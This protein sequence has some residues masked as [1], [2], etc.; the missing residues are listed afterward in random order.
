YT[1]KGDA[2]RAL[3]AP[4]GGA[5]LPPAGDGAVVIDQASGQFILKTP[6]TCG[7]FTESGIVDAGDL[8]FDV[9]GTAATVWV[10]ALDGASIRESPRL[11]LTHLTD[12]QNSGIRYAQQS[13]KTLLAWGGLPHLARNGK[14]EIRLAVNQPGAC[15]VYALSAGG[16]RVAQVETRVVKG[17]LAF[18]AAVDARPDAATLVYEIVRE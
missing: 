7:G 14:A 13:R 11:I 6:R 15:K 8:I 9:G 5:A 3:L 10:S 16:R 12:V 2:I 1:A 18:T 17:R 4:G